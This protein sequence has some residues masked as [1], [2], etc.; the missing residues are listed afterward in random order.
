MARSTRSAQTNQPQKGRKGGNSSNSDHELLSFPYPCDGTAPY[1]FAQVGRNLGVTGEN[2]STVMVPR[3][4]GILA[5]FPSLQSEVLDGR[6][7]TEFGFQEIARLQHYT[8]RK[9]PQRQEDT[10]VPFEIEKTERT[11]VIMLECEPL[12]SMRDYTAWRQKT[13]ALE[14]QAQQSSQSQKKKPGSTNSVID[15]TFVDE[16][17]QTEGRIG[18]DDVRDTD[19]VAAPC[20]QQVD[21]IQQMRGTADTFGDRTDLS[22]DL[23]RDGNLGFISSTLMLAQKSGEM[24]GK[25]YA[26]Q[27]I[28]SATKEIRQAQHSLTE[29][30][31]EGFDSRSPKESE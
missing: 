27:M 7:I 24:L 26:E 19:I 2:V 23:I 28:Q 11:E 29:A 22:L 20:R 9:K 14:H 21:S 31:K 1:S 15:A 5:P 13:I 6:K 30:V 16:S 25:A 18:F 8:S 12:L 4:Q 10:L 3:V 17:E